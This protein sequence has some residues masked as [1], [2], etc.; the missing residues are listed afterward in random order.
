[1]AGYGKVQIEPR[2]EDGV[3][4]FLYPFL[5]NGYSIWN[6]RIDQQIGV[7]GVYNPVTDQISFSN[8]DI[9]SYEYASYPIRSQEEVMENL[10]TGGDYFDGGSLSEYAVG[11]KLNIPEVVYVVKWIEKEKFF[12]PA[13][14]FT[15][16]GTGIAEVNTVYKELVDF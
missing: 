11:V 8:I 9:A 13:L 1:M 5:F 6:P 7:K 3:V 16:N 4:D 10:P 12:I 15:V 2:L 14:R